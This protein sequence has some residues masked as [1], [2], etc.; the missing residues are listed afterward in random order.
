MVVTSHQICYYSRKRPAQ[1]HPP[2]DITITSSSLLDPSFIPQSVWERL[3]REILCL[4]ATASCDDGATDAV[5]CCC[6]IITTSRLVGDGVLKVGW[7]AALSDW[8]S[9]SS[10]SEARSRGMQQ[11]RQLR[12]PG[13]T[14]RSVSS[15]TLISQHSQ[16]VTTS[17]ER[18]KSHWKQ[19][20]NFE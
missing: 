2:A 5:F 1:W 18:G 15:Q 10:I 17:Q 6:R 16:A 7:D 8:H 12:L 11:L 20:V 19:S 13:R 4:W 14:G 3:E 9:S